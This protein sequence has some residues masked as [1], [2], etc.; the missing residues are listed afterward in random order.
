MVGWLVVSNFFIWIWWVPL[1]LV[2]AALYGLFVVSDTEKTYRILVWV[3]I[4]APIVVFG[5]AFL[6]TPYGSAG[7]CVI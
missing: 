5:I 4:T 3:L 2:C 6:L 7:R 1:A